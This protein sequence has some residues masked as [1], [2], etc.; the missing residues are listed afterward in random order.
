MPPVG[1]HSGNRS[2]LGGLKQRTHP[3]GQDWDA[4]MCVKRLST[5][6]LQGLSDVLMKWTGDQQKG[7]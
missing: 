2:D 6:Q 4:M 3:V 1:W 5:Q 7:Q